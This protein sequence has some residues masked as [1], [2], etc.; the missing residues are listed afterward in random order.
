MATLAAVM[1][2]T[3]AQAGV[4]RVYGIPGDSANAIT[5]SLRKHPAIE[6]VHVRNEEAAAFAAGAEGQLTG[7]LTAILGSCGP[8]NLHFINGLYD[9]QRSRVPVLVI[10][11][12]IP[13]SEL[14]TTYFQETNPQQLFKDCSHYV[15]VISEPAHMPRI[16]AIAMRTAIAERGVAES[17]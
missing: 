3:L 4:Q 14:G 15:G 1:I 2:D 9:C 13:S 8:G 17:P 16:L 12:Q 7:K 5:D 11:T 6:W 10:A